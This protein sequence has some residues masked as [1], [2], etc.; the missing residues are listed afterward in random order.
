MDRFE[1]ITVL[2]AVAFTISYGIVGSVPN[3]VPSNQASL[4]LVALTLIAGLVISVG[5]LYYCWRVYQDTKEQEKSG[6]WAFGV[7]LIGPV[8]ALLYAFLARRGK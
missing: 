7:F 8:L 2:Y 3:T 6:F 1:T 4:G 5:H